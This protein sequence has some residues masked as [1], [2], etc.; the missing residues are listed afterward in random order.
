[1]KSGSI[2]IRAASSRAMSPCSTMTSP[3][4]SRPAS[5]S[6]TAASRAH[7]I[8]QVASTSAISRSST[9]MPSQST[10]TRRLTRGAEGRGALRIHLGA[11]ARGSTTPIPKASRRAA[12]PSASHW[13][14]RPSICSTAICA[15][16]RPTSSAHG[17][18]PKSARSAIAA[19]GVEQT[20]LGS[21]G[22]YALFHLG[23]SYAVAPN[24]KLGAAIYNI[25][26]TDFVSYERYQ[27]GNTVAY[28]AEYSNQSGT[29]PR[30]AQRHRRF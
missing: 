18:A 7:S 24:F 6:S 16:R 10:S 4:R 3:T 25:L 15:G 9:S 12:P 5:P 19:A 11:L 27:N 1:M 22:G 2:M 13:S 14:T 30:A 20:A 8:A 17:C 28:G 23:G 29:A 26:D 21:Y